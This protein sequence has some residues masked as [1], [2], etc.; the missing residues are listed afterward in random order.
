MV[1]LRTTHLSGSLAVRPRTLPDNEK[2]YRVTVTL[3][4]RTTLRLAECQVGPE[5]NGTQGR[6]KRFGLFESVGMAA[7]SLDNGGRWAASTD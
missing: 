4:W 3:A 1:G 2:L 7:M 5:S 6:L